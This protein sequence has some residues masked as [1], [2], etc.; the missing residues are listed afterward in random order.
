M[1]EALVNWTIR[2][3]SGSLV[4]RIDRINFGAWVMP[5]MELIN[6]YMAFS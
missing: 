4:D 1:V 6:S 2:M 5:M 3:T